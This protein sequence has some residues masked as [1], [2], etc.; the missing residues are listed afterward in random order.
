MQCVTRCRIISSL[1][2]SGPSHLVV[3]PGGSIES[4]RVAFTK[5]RAL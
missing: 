5:V 4:P 3:D 1:A 2:I